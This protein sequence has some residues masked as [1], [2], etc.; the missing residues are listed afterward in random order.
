MLDL[1]D[2][3][4]KENAHLALSAFV[5]WYPTDD[6]MLA[7]LINQCLQVKFLA[8]NCKLTWIISSNSMIC[9]LQNH[10]EFS[11]NLTRC[12]R[13]RVLNV[14]GAFAWSGCSVWL[15]GTWPI[16]LLDCG[17]DYLRYSHSSQSCYTA[18][19]FDAVILTF[20]TL[21]C[22]FRVNDRN[23]QYFDSYFT[24]WVFR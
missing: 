16:F 20:S 15:K 21:E 4:L 1:M 18:M 3:K 2:K 12:L 17:L 9:S 19:L 14:T 11:V 7:S 6:A 10:S 22:K 8:W 23:R 24:C 13:I 5:R